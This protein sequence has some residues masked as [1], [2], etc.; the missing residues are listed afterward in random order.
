MT[1][2]ER[3]KAAGRWLRRLG[4][5]LSVLALVVPPAALGLV[6]FY[7][8]RP[9]RAV[10]DAA[11]REAIAAASAGTVAILTYSAD[12]L[13][14]DF[15]A[16]RSHLTGDFS[17]YYD[18]FTKQTVAPAAQQN[19]VNTT[20]KVLR[21]ALSEFRPDSAVAL[22]FIEQ[23]TRSKDQ[24]EPVLTSGSVLV[25]LVKTVDRWLI[26]QFKPL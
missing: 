19:S 9:D 8:Y 7:T 11:A 15:S 13:E 14:R 6:Y 16:A 18:N 22:L 23:A 10:D 4:M 24:P 21:G 12:T 20:A 5:T 25:T 17:S 3:S 2:K 26:S 1:A